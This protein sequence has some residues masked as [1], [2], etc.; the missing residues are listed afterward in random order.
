M[1]IHN[2]GVL[3]PILALFATFGTPG[4]RC[5]GGASPTHDA[6]RRLAHWAFV[7]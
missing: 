2:G 3:W 1:V 5:S 7:R 4:D 6:I